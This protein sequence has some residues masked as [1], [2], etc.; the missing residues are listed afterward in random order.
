M[1][2]NCEFCNIDEINIF[3]KFYVICMPELTY[4]LI[5]IWREGRGIA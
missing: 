1:R 3:W 4:V 5:Y 2:M